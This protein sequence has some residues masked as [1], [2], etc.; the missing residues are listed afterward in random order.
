MRDFPRARPAL[1]L[2]GLLIALFAAPAAWAGGYTIAAPLKGMNRPDLPCCTPIYLLGPPVL[3][4]DYVVFTS[5]NGPPDGIWSWRISKKKLKK[6]AGFETK[7]PGGSGDFTAFGY[8]GSELPTTIGGSVVAFYARDAKNAIGLYTVSVNGGAIIRIASTKT[9]A[10]GLG[11]KFTDI[12]YASTNGKTIAFWANV[13]SNVPGIYQAAVDGADLTSVIDG[14]EPLDARTPSGPAEDYFDIFTRPAVGK[15]YVQFYAQGLFDPVTGPNAIFRGKGGF[16]DV[17]DNM[18]A[19]EGGGDEQHVRIG[20]FSASTGSGAV[21]FAADEPNTGYAGLFKVKNMDSAPVFV[22]TEHMVPGKSVPFATF[23]GFGYDES[24]LAF[25]AT[26]VEDEQGV[27][28]VFFVDKP[29][30][31]PARVANGKKYY[32][33]AV[34]DRSISG[35][36]IVFWENSNGADTFYL[37]TP[38]D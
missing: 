20:L 13:Q 33:P 24:G 34:G 23:L 22:S 31:T 27:Q 35:G 9:V 11:E 26:Y 4:G 38:K 8:A 17:A 21:A 15:A 14:T 16:T 1:A 18:T 10:P 12:R 36:R 32:L 5:R 25:T 7:A 30:G 19:L 37:A 28:S 3:S 6:L 29:G 2:L